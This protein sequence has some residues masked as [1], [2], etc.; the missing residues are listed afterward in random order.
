MRNYEHS[1]RGRN[2]NFIIF[3]EPSGMIAPGE[4]SFNH[5]A[6]RRFFPLMRLDFLRYVSAK[7][8]LLL[9][10]RDKSAPISSVCAKLPDRRIPLIRWPCGRY[11]AFSVMNI[12]GMD[13]D[14]QQ[15][16]QHIHYGVPFPAFCFFPPSIPACST[17]TCASLYTVARSLPTAHLSS[18]LGTTSVLFL[19][20]LYFTTAFTSCEYSF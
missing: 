16:A 9:H 13:R 12:S 6:P 2:G 8:K 1:L 18:R 5:P 20:C 10:I 3:T 14:G 7:I 17:Y 15:T 4:G 11:S 19:P